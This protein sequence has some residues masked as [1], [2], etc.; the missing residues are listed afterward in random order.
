MKRMLCLLMLIFSVFGFSSC[1]SGINMEKLTDYQ[2]KDFS[3]FANVAID[4]VKYK[5]NVKTEKLFDVSVTDQLF[6][7][8]NV[9]EMSLNPQEKY[10]CLPRDLIIKVSLISAGYIKR[11]FYSLTNC[12]FL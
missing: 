12:R 3:A 10:I 2:N 7:G 1:S 6:V 9:D 11:A 8:K 5:I 4:G